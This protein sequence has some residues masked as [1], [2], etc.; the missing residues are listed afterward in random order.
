MQGAFEVTVGGRL[1]HSRL[2]IQGHG[3][4]ETAEELD[5]LVE[6]IEAELGR[7]KPLSKP[8]NSAATSPRPPVLS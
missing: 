3:K 8:A 5:A 1:V 7:R 2:K 6:T 4:C